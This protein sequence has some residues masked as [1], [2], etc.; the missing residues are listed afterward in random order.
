MIKRMF[1]RVAPLL[2]VASLVYSQGPRR[3][4]APLNSSDPVQFDVYNYGSGLCN[5]VNDNTP[6]VTAANDAAKVTGGIIIYPP[7]TCMTSKQLL[8]TGVHHQGAG[9]GVSTIMLLPN[10][11]SDLFTGSVSGYSNG[12]LV[13]PDAPQNSGTNDAVTATGFTAITLDGNAT[14]QT[15]TSWVVRAYWYNV[16]LSDVVIRNGFSG[17]LY[18]DYNGAA[19]SDRNQW[20]AQSSNLSVHDCGSVEGV[21]LHDGAPGILWAGPHDAQFSNT[22]VFHTTGVPLYTGINAVA[23]MWTNLHAW[24]PRF[25]HNVPAILNEAGATI[26]SGGE[27]EG[28]DTVQLA[29]LAGDMTWSG[30]VFAAPSGPYI[31]VQLGQTA[32]QNPFP[33]SHYQASPG[34]QNPAPGSSVAVAATGT[35]LTGKCSYNNSG[36]ISFA[37]ETKNFVSL[38]AYQVEG[39]YYTGTPSP[40]DSIHIDGNGITPTGGN[41]ATGSFTQIPCYGNNGHVIRSPSGTQYLDLNCTDGNNSLELPN[42]TKLQLYADNYATPQVGITGNAVTF[43][44]NYAPVTTLKFPFPNMVN[45]SGAFATDEYPVLQTIEQGSTIMFASGTENYTVVPI[46]TLGSTIGGVI[47]AP[48]IRQGQQL[49]VLNTSASSIALAPAGSNVAGATTL[50]PTKGA[51]FTWDSNTSLWYPD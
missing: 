14:Q 37:N 19:P 28:S 30:W 2:F 46:T 15:A 1:K 24:G 6:G 42:A 43:G 41:E 35:Y 51:S 13:L 21:P 48:G 3:P 7:G 27:A 10:Q 32:G 39:Q 4:R 40:L 44:G 25:G 5:G 26:V 22:L 9:S 18:S 20:L 36:C 12:S 49:K 17:C 33:G 47:I 34:D 29:D 31:G 23:T 16:T 11:N 50:A 45:L 38:L 8:Y